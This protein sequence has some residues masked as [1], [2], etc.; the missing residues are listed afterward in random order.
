MLL[1]DLEPGVLGLAASEPTPAQPAAR[2]PLVLVVDDERDVLDALETALVS[3]GWRVVTAVNGADALDKALQLR[4]DLVLTDLLMPVIDGIG[5]AKS[6]RANPS[7]ATTC[8]VLCSGVSEASVKGLFDGY[9]AFLHKP[10]E[11][12][13]LQ[14][15]IAVLR[16]Q[17]V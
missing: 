1:P 6:L 11:L 14:R 3:Q 13:D 2:R 17:H 8:I 10:Y 5:L 7:T 12:D 4:P 16:P 15:A 9:D